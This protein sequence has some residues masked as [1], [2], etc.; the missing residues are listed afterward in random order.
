MDFS[1][2]APER[3]FQESVRRLAQ[4]NLAPAALRRAHDP[5]FPFEV[6]RAMAEAGLI[7]LMLPEADGGGGG[8]LLQAV[9]ALQEIALACPRSADVFQAGN[10]GAFRTL[11]EYATPAQKERFFAPLLKG[12]KIAAVA[13]TEP[14]AGS[15]VTDLKTRAE[16]DGAGYRLNGG[17]IFTTNAEEASLFLVYCRFSP[18]TNGIGSV[19]V[20]PGMEGFRLGTPSRYMNGES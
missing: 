18:G 10:F 13:M 3:A 6:A 7:G 12:Q 14:E 19:L 2:S 16:P 1:F 11:A 20:E 17:K 15:A 9:L 8:S 4:R 5:R